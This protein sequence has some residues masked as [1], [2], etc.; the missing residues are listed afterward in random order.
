MIIKEV[1]SFLESWAPKSLQESYDNSGLIV[2]D[3]NQQITQALVSLDCTEEVVDDAIKKGCNLIISH[4]PIVFKGLK[5][6]TGKNYVERTVLKAIK[7]DIALYAIHTNLDNV[8]TGV[9]FE[10]MKRLNISN[11][12]IL[13]PKDSLLNKLVVYIP[14]THY[15]EVLESMFSAGAGAIGNYSECSFRQQG[16]GSFKPNENTQA[17]IGEVGVRHFE[18]EERVEVLVENHRLSKVLATMI[19]SHPYEEVA[20]D[21]V[22]LSNKHQQIGA[23]MVGE[24]DEAIDVL[25]F[26]KDLKEKFNVGCIRHTPLVKKKVKRI[27]VCGGSGSFLIHAAKA[28]KV[29]VYITGDVKYHE[30]FDA[31]NQVVIADIGHFE[32]EQFTIELLINEIR[33]KFPNFAPLKTDVNTNPLSYL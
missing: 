11:P 3:E 29:D 25:E 26:F 9:N 6:L 19:N 13:S 31:D 16:V 10:I 4:H 20:Y 28:S 2:G 30:F 7:N 33:E 21:I 32:S 23:G 1:I 24:L 27:A 8:H 18:E 5:S 22:P 17:F 12:T 14:K 15:E